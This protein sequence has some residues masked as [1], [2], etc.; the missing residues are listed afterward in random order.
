MQTSVKR[1]KNKK[2][3]DKAVEDA[4]I[5]GWTLS[6]QGSNTAVFK[7]AGGYGSLAGHLIVLLLTG[8][9]TLLFGNFIY[10]IVSHMSSGKELRIKI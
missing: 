8:W 5:E 9:W 2:E 10:G 4:E 7:K 6:S 1:V 3:F